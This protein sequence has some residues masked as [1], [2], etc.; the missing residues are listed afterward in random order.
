MPVS[1]DTGLKDIETLAE[2]GM[3]A[4][5]G[6]MGTVQMLT[7]LPISSTCFLR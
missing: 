3:F 6:R 4:A 1:G 5:A 7:S 2:A